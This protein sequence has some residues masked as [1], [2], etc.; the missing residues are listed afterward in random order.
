MRMSQHFKCWVTCGHGWVCIPQGQRSCPV[1]L[2]CPSISHRPV[3]GKHCSENA[4]MH[5][6]TWRRNRLKYTTLPWYVGL[7]QH[8]PPPTANLVK[9]S[10]WLVLKRLSNVK[11]KMWHLPCFL[12]RGLAGTVFQEADYKTL[13]LGSRQGGHLL[14]NPMGTLSS[15]VPSPWAWPSSPA[16]SPGEG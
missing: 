1:H 15:P 4:W 12:V 7:R 2:W 14:L 11:Y 10:L 6:S 13:G 9:W 8:P 16:C 3:C 5:V